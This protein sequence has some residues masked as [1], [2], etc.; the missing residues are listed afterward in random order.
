MPRTRPNIAQNRTLVELHTWLLYLA[1]VLGLSMSPGPNGLLALTHGAVHG[2]RKAAF[3]VMGG[4]TGFVAV[5]ALSMFGIGALLQTSATALTI[6]K[7]VGGVYLVWLGV[8]V[9][10]SPP[11]GVSAA[12]TTEAATGGALFLQGLLS[13]VTNP[14]VLLF[15]SAF[16]P[17]FIDPARPIST[18]FLFIAGTFAAVEVATEMLIAGMAQRVTAWLARAGRGFNHVCGAIIAAIGVLLPLKG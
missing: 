7:W 14:K 12:D 9:W 11:V 2:C 3:T 10:R 6:M 4:A 5:I 17:S 8:Q 15:F 16:L 13:A 18:Q 1:A